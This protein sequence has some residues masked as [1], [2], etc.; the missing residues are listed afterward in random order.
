VVTDNH[1]EP[2][3]EEIR[4]VREDLTETCETC[5][6]I[7]SVDSKFSEN[8]VQVWSTRPCER[9]MLCR[10]VSVG[11]FLCTSASLDSDE[12][13][14]VVCLKNIVS[15]LHAMPNLNHVHTLIEH[16]G[17]CVLPS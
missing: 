6:Q 3:L 17:Y 1:E 2:S 16:Y 7:L 9:G 14:E 10:G 12:E 11:T 8:Q 4:C 15:S 13:L 5:D